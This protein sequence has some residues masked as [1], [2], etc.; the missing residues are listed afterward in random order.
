MKKEK[1]KRALALLCVG[2]MTVTGVNLPAN[3]MSTEAAADWTWNALVSESGYIKVPVDE[4]TAEADTEASN[5]GASSGAGAAYPGTGKAGNIVDGVLGSYYHSAYNGDKQ[6]IREN[7]TLTGNNTITLT[8]DS[9]KSVQGVTYLPRQDAFGNGPITEFTVK[10][11]K[12]GGTTWEDVSGQFKITYEDAGANNWTAEHK[13]EREFVFENVIDNVKKIQFTVKHT[14]GGSPNQHI[15]GTEISVLTPE[16]ENPEIGALE[17]EIKA[18]IAKAEKVMALNVLQNDETSGKVYDNMKFNKLKAEA[19][20]LL[21]KEDV[22]KEE[23]DAVLSELKSLEYKFSDKVGTGK[24]LSDLSQVSG[25]SGW[26]GIVKDQ[27]PD[28][29]KLIAIRSGEGDKIN[30][31]TKGIGAHEPSTVVYDVE[32][33]KLFTADIGVE[34]HHVTS[35]SAPDAKAHF[36]VSVSADNQTYEEIYDNKQIS[37]RSG[38]ES[39]KVDIPSGMKYLKLECRNNET[40]KT[41]HTCWANAKVYD[42]VTVADITLDKESLSLKTG[43]KATLTPTFNPTNATNKEVAWESEDDSIATVDET[44]K[45]TAVGVGETLITVKS[46]ENETITDSCIVTVTADKTALLR[47]IAAA[48]AKME[49][50]DFEVKYTAESL[51]DFTEAYEY[52]ADVNAKANATTGEVN[53]ATE[54]LNA[55]IESLEEKFVVTI[56]NNGTTETKYCEVGDQVTVVAKPAPEGQKFSHWTVNGTPISYKESYTFTVYGDTTV[57]AKYVAKEEV[58]EQEATIMCTSYYD[59]ATSKVVFTAKRSLPAGCKVVQHGIIVTDSTGWNNL[60]EQGFVIGAQGT[61]KGAG[62]TT[63]LL[64]NYT[65]RMKSVLGDTWYGRGYVIYTDKN[66]ETHTL[67]SNVTSS[68]ATK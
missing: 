59:V 4:L 12:D 54:S 15:S 49:E 45:V 35:N 14:S 52:A 7:G 30:T 63:G 41:L 2:A 32:G 21:E 39:I 61:V 6:P 66:G 8:L 36:V 31:Y 22:Q 16:K 62:K 26:H 60:G 5:E 28:Q 43:E 51:A 38:L 48:D 46:K 67:Y 19:E 20:D 18:L 23:L 68:Q 56:N 33:Y 40:T 10:V 55:A 53:I 42:S 3:V 11:Q 37:A 17:A 47:A 44:G 64:G 50:E 9:A 25:T 24:Y 1:M 58:V 57:E 27:C 13:S 65:C 29:N 34:A